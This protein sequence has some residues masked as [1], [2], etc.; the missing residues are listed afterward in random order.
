MRKT[1]LTIL[2]I[3]PG[4]R[5][6]GLAVMRDGELIEW[7]I[8]T[9]KGSWSHGKLKD[10]LFVLTRYI[11]GH[12]VKVITLKKPDNHRSS[13]GL[14]QLV[15]ELTVWA[16]MNR[17]KV[18]SF[19]LP[20]MKKQFSKE[21]NFGKTEMIKQVALRYPELYPEYNKEQRNKR[22]YYL[23]MVE[24]VAIADLVSKGS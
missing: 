1:P 4:T 13:T 18:V 16:K 6:I 2:G 17:I 10:I 20:E 14:D 12:R 3:S 21:K 5:S 24:A 7:R 15:S 11:E 22:E 9:F 8:K 23:K 19:T